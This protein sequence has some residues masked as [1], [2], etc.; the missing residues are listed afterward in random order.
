VPSVPTYGPM[1]NVLP[2]VD[3][4]MLTIAATMMEQE[5]KFQPKPETDTKQPKKSSPNGP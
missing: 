3:P 5:G 1:G 4:T 2:M